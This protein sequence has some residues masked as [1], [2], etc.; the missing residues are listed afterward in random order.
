MINKLSMTQAMFRSACNPWNPGNHST[1]GKLF[2]GFDD[3]QI[4]DRSWN[5]GWVLIGWRPMFSQKNQTQRKRHLDF[6]VFKSV[7][8]SPFYQV[9]E[10]ENPPGSYWTSMTGDLLTFCISD[11]VHT[12][13][14]LKTHLC[15]C[16]DIQMHSIHTSRYLC[17][18][19]ANSS[20]VQTKWKSKLCW[21][22]PWK[23]IRWWVRTKSEKIHFETWHIS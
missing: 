11:F 7:S 8:E 14:L 6:F 10:Q 15:F 13:S 18:S 3:V 21:Q 12:Q 22:Y 4:I 23:G 5:R 9:G 2:L 16:K 17:D 19:W 1:W 20:Y